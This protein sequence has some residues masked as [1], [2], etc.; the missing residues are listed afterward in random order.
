MFF[1]IDNQGN[2]RVPTFE[3]R[4]KKD[5]ELGQQ[6]RVQSVDKTAESI[7]GWRVDGQVDVLS[8]LVGGRDNRLD[9]L[10]ADAFLKRWLFTKVDYS[11]V[12]TNEAIE[13]ARKLIQTTSERHK[14]IRTSPPLVSRTFDC[15]LLSQSKGFSWIRQ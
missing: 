15:A 6:F 11:T 12:R 2:I 5:S 8:E 14:I 1:Y 3:F 10:R 7:R 13:F 4:L 9:D